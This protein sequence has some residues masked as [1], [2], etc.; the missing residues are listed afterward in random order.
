[1]KQRSSWRQHLFC[2]IEGQLKLATGLVLLLGFSIA[3]LG[4]LLVTRQNLVHDL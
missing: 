2:S 1:M 3:S 4:T